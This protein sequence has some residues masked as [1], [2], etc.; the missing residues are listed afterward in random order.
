[1]P[2]EKMQELWQDVYRVNDVN[3]KIYVKLQLSVNGKKV[4]IVQFKKK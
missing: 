3:N 2:S 1:M 4:V